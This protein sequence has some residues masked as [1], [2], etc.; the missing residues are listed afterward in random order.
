MTTEDIEPMI[1]K[2]IVKIRKNPKTVPIKELYEALSEELDASFWSEIVEELFERKLFQNKI[3]ELIRGS[4]S[5]YDPSKQN[6]KQLGDDYRIVLGWYSSIKNGRSLYKKTDSGKQLI[7]IEDCKHLAFLIFKEMVKRGFTFN[8]PETYKKNARELYEWIISQVGEKNVPFEGEEE[9]T[10]K[11]DPEM[12]KREDLEK[13]DPEYL[14]T[15]T[16]E[17]L[18]KSVV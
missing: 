5:D 9:A 15:L 14:K 8:K 12:I 17:D 3:I 1:P 2:V 18:R 4:I 11:L 16:D 7:T 13:I 6:E 10:L